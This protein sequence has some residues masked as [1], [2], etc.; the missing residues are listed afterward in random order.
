MKRTSIRS[1]IVIKPPDKKTGAEAPGVQQILQTQQADC[2]AHD[3][4]D[5]EA[6]DNPQGVNFLT[7]QPHT[8]EGQ[9]QRYQA[10]H[11]LVEDSLHGGDAS[12]T[13]LT[14]DG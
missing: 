14:G 1:V 11:Q 2:V 9:Q 10:R 3:T 13:I 6:N 12:L 5:E 8:S 4:D 7:Q